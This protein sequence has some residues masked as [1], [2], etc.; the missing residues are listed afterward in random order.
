MTADEHESSESVGQGDEFVDRP[1]PVVAYCGDRRRERVVVAIFG[2]GIVLSLVML[3]REVGEFR[4]AGRIIHNA[5]VTRAEIAAYDRGEMLLQGLWLV[6]HISAAMAFLMWIYRA[7][8]NLPA[9][10]ATELRFTPWGAVGW[11]FFPYL[12][13]FKPYQCMR[14]IYNASDIESA[15]GSGPYGIGN[16]AP[17]VVKT[18]W[19]LFLMFGVFS[20]A[21][22]MARSD[23]EGP[24][25]LQ[26]AAVGS[27][28]GEAFGLLA[29]VAAI[30][31]VRSVSR[32]QMQRAAA[33]G[34]ASGRS[35]A[36]ALST[37]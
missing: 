12:N 32:R 2:V 3:I 20:S 5:P 37:A 27:S 25:A 31:V 30:S 4:L 14:E 11:Y 23:V 18:W 9:L 19:G 36:T 24:A 34:L 16:Y 13:L 22:Y 1:S 35:T 33:L 21:A 6:W 10:G 7:H 15:I 29:I 26:V 28:I 8:R 17:A